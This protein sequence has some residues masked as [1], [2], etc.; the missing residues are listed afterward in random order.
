MRADAASKFDSHGAYPLRVR[1]MTLLHHRELVAL[2]RF[3]IVCP[4]RDPMRGGWAT[5]RIE[6]LAASRFLGSGA[7]RRLPP[8]V[9]AIVRTAQPSVS[10]SADTC[11]PVNG[12][13]AKLRV[14][15]PTCGRTAQSACSVYW[16]DQG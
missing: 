1:Q 16:L 6:R 14:A 10:P 2:R 12:R 5:V 7:G 8:G 3:S 13:M 9:R 4:H 11:R 15:E